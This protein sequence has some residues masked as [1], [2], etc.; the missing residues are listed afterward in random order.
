MSVIIASTVCVPPGNAQAPRPRQDAT[1]VASRAEN[2]CITSC[3]FDIQ[4]PGL[5]RVFDEW[6]DHAAVD[7]HFMAPH[8]ASS[9]VA[10][11]ELGVSDR[12]AEPVRGRLQTRPSLRFPI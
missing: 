6:R 7:A 12:R 5:I 9:R 4:D 2:E 10:N 3:A 8:M 11:A 1:L